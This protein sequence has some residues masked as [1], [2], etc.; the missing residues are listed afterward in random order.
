MAN[1]A[2]TLGIYDPLFYAQ[3]ALIQLEKA[4][5][6]AGRVHRGYDSSPQ[7]LGSTIQIRRP[8]TFV[9]T[10]MPDTGNTQALVP[11]TVTITLDQWFGVKF[12]LTDKEL[13]Y[14]KEQIITEHIRPAAYAVAD[15]ID[16]TVAALYADIPWFVDADTGGLVTDW[17]T[18]WRVLFDNSVPQDDLH[19]ML[20]GERTSKYLALPAFSQWQGAGDAGVTTQQRGTLGIK[21][22]FEAFSNQNVQIAANPA[23]LA[24]VTQLQLNAGALK[25]ASQIVVKDSD[26]VLTGV[27]TKGDSLVIAGS[28]QRYAV[29]T[30]AT[31]AANL[32]TLNITPLLTKDYLTNDN[33]TLRQQTGKSENLGFHRGA[34]ALAMAPLSDAGNAIGARIGTANDPVTNLSI[35]SSMWYVGDSAQIFVRLDALWGVKTLNP[36]MAV[37][38][39]A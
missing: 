23:P 38:L 32:V 31:A 39:N 7:Q 2:N 22:G 3:E 28:A 4:L 20:N 15:K 18:A 13:T 30:T 9:A 6:L 27:V 25:G 29:T 26:A 12:T 37:R 21:Y 24:T 19:M 17:T 10:A 11:D 16:Q 14:T 34:L 33:V 5:G 36:N 1:P 8:G 35:R